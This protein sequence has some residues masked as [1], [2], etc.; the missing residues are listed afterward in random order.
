M[1]PVG[2]LCLFPLL[3]GY[4]R[5]PLFPSGKRDIKLEISSIIGVAGVAMGNCGTHASHQIYYNL[6]KSLAKINETIATAFS[7]T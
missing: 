6:C 5:V 4:A 1:L 3:P 2:R 7:D